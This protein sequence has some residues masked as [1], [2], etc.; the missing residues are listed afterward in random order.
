[1]FQVGTAPPSTT[2]AARPVQVAK[3]VGIGTLVLI[4]VAVACAGVL[5]GGLLSVVASRTGAAETR[6]VTA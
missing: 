3:G 4:G 6:T 2:P 1:M 5:L